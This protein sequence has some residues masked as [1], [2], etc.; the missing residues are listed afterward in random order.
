MVFEKDTLT[1]GINLVLISA[2]IKTLPGR[3]LL[4]IK[5]NEF[6]Y[7]QTFLQYKEMLQ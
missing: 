7:L 5:K 1:G 2:D 6:K 4:Y 3:I